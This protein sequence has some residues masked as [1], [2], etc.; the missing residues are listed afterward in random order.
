MP[1]PVLTEPL[2]H[3]NREGGDGMALLPVV[4]GTSRP[5]EMLG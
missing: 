1:R 5:E 4:E 3:P 2:D